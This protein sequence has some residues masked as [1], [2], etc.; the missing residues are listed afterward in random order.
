MYIKKEWI[1]TFVN[2]CLTVLGSSLLAFGICAFVDP[3]G[4]VV[5]GATGIALVVHRIFGLS[6]SLVTLIINIAVLVPG[7]FL[8]GRKLVIGSVFS[9]LVCPAAMAVFERL[10]WVT[11]VVDNTILAAICGGVVCGSGI[12]LVMRGGASTGG[13]DIPVLILHKYL[14]LPVNTIM[15]LTDGCVML[16][17]IPI[18]GIT[19]VIYGLIYTY[20]MTSTLGT[21]L[22][23]GADRLRIT[24]VSEAYEEI[25]HALTENDFGVTMIYAEGG[26]TRT[27]IKQLESVM[28]SERYRKAQRIIEEI[29]PTAFITIEKVKDVKGRGFT[30][31]REWLELE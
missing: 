8:G 19:A 28:I 20:I 23:Y 4:L 6:I 29:D 25:C 11:S 9:S 21:V 10:P 7:Y 15:N 13:L 24:I 27:P 17:Q 31:E 2:I 1:E 16:A 22:T 3:F 14:H 26:Y 18:S 12:A 5:G 30:L